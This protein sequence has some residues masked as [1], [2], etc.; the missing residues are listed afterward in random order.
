M[1]FGDFVRVKAGSPEWFASD[2][3]D[4]SY[5]PRWIYGAQLRVIRQ[6]SHNHNWYP[7]V[8]YVRMAGDQDGS[9]TDVGI[10]YLEPWRDDEIW[11][12]ESR[13]WIPRYVPGDRVTYRVRDDQ[14]A[15]LPAPP[16]L[17]GSRQVTWTTA[18]VSS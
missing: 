2:R 12:I 10:Q 4:R 15:Y 8:V 1:K 16:I 11:H 5:P 9:D 14:P 3:N 6:P 7:G 13:R 18:E 17:Y